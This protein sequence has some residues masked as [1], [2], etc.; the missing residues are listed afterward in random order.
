MQFDALKRREFIT[1]LGGAAMW[2][3]PARAQQ[4]AVPI[5][6]FFSSGSWD[7]D[8][9][10]LVGF[11]QGLS[12]SRNDIGNDRLQLPPAD[13][14]FHDIRWRRFST[15]AAL[16]A[17]AATATIPIVFA[18]SADPVAAGLVAS[19]NR[20]GGNLTGLTAVS[21]VLV[22]KR[23]QLLRELM[24]SLSTVAV[25]VNPT[26]LSVS[27]PKIREAQN[28]ARPLGLQV[29][30]LN[31]SNEQEIDAGFARLARLQA[32]ALLISTESLFTNHREKLTELAL[33]YKIP[34]IYRGA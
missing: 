11:R 27:E 32:G 26:N 15:P 13:L 5:I 24:P 31:V 7:A 33:R 21:E 29:H 14:P 1:L 34:A 8:T 28:S 12:E 18:I 22:P 9:I 20:P 4:P 2:P 6:A 23:L 30:F 16:A 19:F 3:I 10:R 17:K 25:L